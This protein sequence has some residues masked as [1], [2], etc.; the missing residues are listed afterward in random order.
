MKPM[1][2]EPRAKSE[3]PEVI[4]RRRQVLAARLA[5]RVAAREVWARPYVNELESQA[6]IALTRHL[7]Q[8][9]IENE[10]H[11]MLRVMGNRLIDLGRT[12]NVDNRKFEKLST[13]V[14]HLKVTEHGG[15]EVVPAGDGFRGLSLN[16]IEDEEAQIRNLQVLAATACVPD[17]DDRALLRTKFLSD[18]DLTL[19]Q[20]GKR[21]G[22][23]TAPGMANHLRRFLGSDDEPGAV[24]PAVVLVGKLPIYMADAYVR[25]LNRYDD[26][27]VL[28]DPFGAAIGHLEFAGRYSEAHRRCAVEG[29]ARLQWLSRNLPSTRGLPNKILRR[30]VIASCFYVLEEDDAVHDQYSAKG[31]A[32]D[33]RVLKATFEVLRKYSAKS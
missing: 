2:T 24:E 8:G 29:K 20:L 17:P 10:E 3:H 12:R 23:K 14:R 27:D 1:G 22:G 4:A 33:V 9:E 25:V 18:E 16:I 19:A 7:E 13:L 11:F 21:F 5:K 31:L 28:S 32:D 26:L 15:H 30:L 6:L